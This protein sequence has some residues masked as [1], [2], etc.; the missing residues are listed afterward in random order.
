MA[1]DVPNNS[2]N[3]VTAQ[4]PAVRRKNIL[5]LLRDWPLNRKIAL[6]VVTFISIALFAFLIIQA[7]VADYQLLYANLSQADAGSVVN[8]LKT[9]NIPYQLKNGGK[10]IWISADK[11]YDTRLNLAANGLPAGGGVGF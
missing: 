1:T 5:T 10:N 9:Q 6:G 4:T 2:A 11:L 3:D 8:W 7:R